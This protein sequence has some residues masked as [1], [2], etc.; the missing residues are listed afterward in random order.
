MYYFILLFLVISCLSLVAWRDPARRLVFAREA[1][2][3]VQ[4][5]GHGAQAV[6]AAGELAAGWRAGER[7]EEKS[8]VTPIDC[9]QTNHCAGH[10]GRH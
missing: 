10:C 7:K 2:P 3:P 6:A 8:C 4:R 5:R 1:A 9:V